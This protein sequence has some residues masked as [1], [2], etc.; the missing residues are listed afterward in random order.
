MDADAAKIPWI[1]EV[2]G[3]GKPTGLHIIFTGETFSILS[4]GRRVWMFLD[5]FS[6]EKKT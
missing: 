1:G 5:N 6:L 2:K 4:L 3:C